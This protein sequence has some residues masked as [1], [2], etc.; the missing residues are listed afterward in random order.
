MPDAQ[1]PKTPDPLA[2]VA[3]ASYDAARNAL[4]PIGSPNT[5]KALRS[6]ASGVVDTLVEAASRAA[7]AIV[8]SRADTEAMALWDT[9]LD[10]LGDDW[11][12][13][14]IYCTRTGRLL[15]RVDP[16]PWLDYLRVIAA[17]P[18][19]SEPRR[20]A[21]SRLLAAIIA[22]KAYAVAPVVL[23]ISGP[24]LQLARAADLR[25]YCVIS[26]SRFF[27]GPQAVTSAS[28][29]A[30]A[31]KLQAVDLARRGEILGQAREMMG[32]LP[33]AVLAYAAE[34]LGLYLSHIDPLRLPPG[35]SPLALYGGDMLAP[36][37][38]VSTV[39]HLCGRL[40]Q[41]MIAEIAALKLRPI[42]ALTKGDLR[43]LRVHYLGSPAHKNSRAETAKLKAAIAQGIKDRAADA[44]ATADRMTGRELATVSALRAD[45]ELSALLDLI[46]LQSAVSA[47]GRTVPVELS[48]SDAPVA[49]SK[50]DA[51]RAAKTAEADN[52]IG[53]LDLSELLALGD[54]PSEFFP[55]IDSDDDLIDLGICTAED[56]A[57]FDFDFAQ[58]DD[59]DDSDDDVDASADLLAAFDLDSLIA[60]A[61]PTHRKPSVPGAPRKMPVAKPA[62]PAPVPNADD[63]L[64]AI[65]QA[66]L[67]A[68]IAPTAPAAPAKPA[69]GTVLRRIAVPAKP[70][71]APTPVAPAKPAPVKLYPRRPA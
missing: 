47:T 39:A 51:L 33:P 55:T 32:E 28:P 56:I 67:D 61:T 5:S 25:D 10:R 70:A 71:P 58:D 60:D 48:A 19:D 30:P 62:K 68:P 35:Q 41:G 44:R 54:L 31:R 50:R 3:R 27:E 36:W 1:P 11:L 37:R 42:A 23:D 40:V 38:S 34:C 6:V 2:A 69:T 16:L 29:G 18:A 45:S 17:M 26:L 57:A 46:D 64:A 53:D 21:E 9:L 13:D 8:Q 63:D 24:G 4:A 59:D 43:R 52:L 7:G 66:A 22:Q 65:L 14:A 15:S 49:I 20:G 12:T